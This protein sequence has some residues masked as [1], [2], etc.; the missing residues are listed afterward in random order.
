MEGYFLGVGFDPEKVVEAQGS[1]N[2]LKRVDSRAKGD[3][4]KK[5]LEEIREL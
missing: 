5:G 4:R 2:H 3:A 1:F